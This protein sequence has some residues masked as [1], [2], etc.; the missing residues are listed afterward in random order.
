MCRWRREFKEQVGIYLTAAFTSRSY[1]RGNHLRL[2]AG[3]SSSHY[4]DGFARRKEL[5]GASSPRQSRTISPFIRK[6]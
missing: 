4:N 6:D 5:G 3:V 1:D 2:A